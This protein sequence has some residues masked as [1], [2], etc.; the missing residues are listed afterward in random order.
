MARKTIVLVPGS[1]SPSTFYTP[2]ADPLRAAGYTVHLLDPPAYYS[3]KAGAPPTIYDDAAHIAAFVRGLVD[4]GEDVVL[5]AHSYGGTPTSQSLLGLT[6]RERRAKG[7]KGGVVRVGYITAVVPP[8]GKNLIEF[9]ATGEQTE[10]L[11]E[12]DKVFCC[13]EGLGFVSGESGFPAGLP[14]STVAGRLHVGG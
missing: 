9:M 2:L 7:E 14:V 13:V 4:A 8:V 11:Y 1:F 12:T 10:G 3:K 5:L 6:A